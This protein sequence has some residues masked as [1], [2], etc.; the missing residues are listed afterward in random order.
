MN[1]K[2][3]LLSALTSLGITQD[4]IPVLY[5]RM[6]S[7][8]TS[9]QAQVNALSAQIETLSAQKA[10]AESKLLA[11]IAIANKLLSDSPSTPDAAP[12]QG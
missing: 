10:E 9:L 11:G 1:L 3:E 8:V 6:M 5:E 7:L 4:E 2:P 12:D